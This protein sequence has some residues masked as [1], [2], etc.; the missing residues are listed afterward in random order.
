M[1]RR[2]AV[3]ALGGYRAAFET[4]EDYDLWL[5]LATVGKLAN[6][7]EP[8]YELRIHGSS[9]T[10]KEGRKKQLDY[11]SLAQRMTLELCL[12][13]QTS[14]PSGKL[15]L[16]PRTAETGQHLHAGLGEVS[17]SDWAQIY[18]W[19]GRIGLSIYLL[20]RALASQPRHAYAWSVVGP[21]YVSRARAW[22]LSLGA[23]RVLR[24][25]G[26]CEW[27]Q[28]AHLMGGFVESFRA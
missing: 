8:L 3:L 6:L 2:A 26:R 12:H 16:P 23:R 5:R 9:K 21:T 28:V 1:M 20:L 25:I 7:T 14:E 17:L 22:E 19:Q 15:R 24:H 10:V 18:F 27:P 4:T 11:S 13:E